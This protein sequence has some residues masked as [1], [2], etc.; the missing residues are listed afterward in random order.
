MWEAQTLAVAFIF[1]A[2]KEAKVEIPSLCGTKRSWWRQFID[3]VDVHDLEGE[4]A[5]SVLSYVTV[6]IHGQAEG[7][8]EGENSCIHIQIKA[9]TRFSSP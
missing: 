5:Y 3:R 1:L 8:V 7:E 2:A 4:Y 9:L 6:S